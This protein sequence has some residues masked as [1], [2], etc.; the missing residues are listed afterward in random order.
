MKYTKNYLFIIVL[1][2]SFS[3]ADNDVEEVVVKA[4]WREA[5]LIEE[6]V[7]TFILGQSEIDSQPIKHFENISYLVPNLNFAA[8]D[9]RAR[10]FQ[11]RGIGERSGYLGTPNS[12]IGFLI[13][14]VDYSGQG[15]IA[16][17]FDVNQ[18]EVI[19]GPQASRIGANALAGLIYI[20]TNEPTNEFEGKSELSIGNYNTSSLGA[21]FGGPVT[22]D[23]TIKFRLAIRQDKSDLS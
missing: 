3:L 13:D 8:S 9:S 1:L 16:T 20:T 6:D 21:A 12:S 11:I 5:K 15:G 2:S 17:L 10:Y 7:S 14:D 4:D 23:K 19:R 22:K 18:I